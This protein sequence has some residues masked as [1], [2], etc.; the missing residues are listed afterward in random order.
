LQRMM[1]T[2]IDFDGPAAVR[3]P[4]GTGVGARLSDNPRP[5]ALGKGEL[6]LDGRDAL[7][8]AIGS[9]VYPALEAAGE[10][11]Q[12][13]GLSVAVFNA[14]FVK[15]LPE[16][17][18]LDLAK[19]FKFV[20]TVEENALAGGFGSAVLELLADRGALDGL[21][22]RRLGLPDRFVEHGKQKELRAMVG[23]DK[24]GMKRAVLEASGLKADRPRRARD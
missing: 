20:L 7:I 16:K 17:Q 23:I 3:Y 6:V 13:Q 18:I 24:N 21:V 5:L 22:L 4:R 11:E 12:E 8:L 2:A 19:R 10:L 9:R 1:I 15:P 14:R